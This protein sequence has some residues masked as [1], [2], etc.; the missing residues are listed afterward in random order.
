MNDSM[1]EAIGEDIEPRLRGMLQ[2][3][4]EAAFLGAPTAADSAGGNAT[5]PRARKVPPAGI[6]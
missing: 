5:R 4:A 2:G 6:S 3:H 1:R